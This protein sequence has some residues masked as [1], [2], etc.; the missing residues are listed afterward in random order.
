MGVTLLLIYLSI[1]FA[2]ELIAILLGTKG[3]YNSYIMSLNSSLYTPFLYGFLFL[4]T[5]TTWKRYFYVF[6]YFILLGYFI[7]GG[8]Y[9]PRSV[10]GGT[11][12]LVIYIPFF[13][14]ALVHLTD[15][16]LDPKNTWFKFR[17]RLSLSMLFFSV[18]ALIIQSFEW[19]YEDKYSSR[20]MIVFYIALSN[21]IL[22]YFALTINFLMECIKLYRKQRLM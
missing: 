4:Y 5:H 19:Y 15:L 1:V 21:N 14:A 11:A 10:L 17:L 16:L 22:Y 3:I 8:Y 6:L 7:S 13:L 18:V 20:P 2:G 12:I 9:H